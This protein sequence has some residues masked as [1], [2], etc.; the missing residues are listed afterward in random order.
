MSDHTNI[1]PVLSAVLGKL[2]NDEERGRV[3]GVGVGAMCKGLS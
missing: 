1:D 3:V 2:P